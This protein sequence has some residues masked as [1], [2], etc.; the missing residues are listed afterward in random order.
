M[1]GT[2]ATNGISAANGT[3]ATNGSSAANGASVANG[4]SASNSTSAASGTSAANDTTS[5]SPG[6]SVSYVWRI[7]LPLKAGPCQIIVRNGIRDYG[8]LDIMMLEK[9]NEATSNLPQFLVILPADILIM[10]H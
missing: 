7:W 6:L 8:I 10:V 2:S 9:L 1:R 4:T 5:F 3:S